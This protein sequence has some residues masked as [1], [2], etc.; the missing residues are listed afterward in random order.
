ML[1]AQRHAVSHIL[2]RVFHV[3]EQRL[4]RGNMGQQKAAVLLLIAMMTLPKLRSKGGR[5]L[6]GVT[7]SV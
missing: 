4:P 3:G 1:P 2:L 5:P 7:L 6:K